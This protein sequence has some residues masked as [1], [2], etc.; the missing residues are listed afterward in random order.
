MKMIG[1]F[2]LLNQTECLLFRYFCLVNK[3]V[4]YFNSNRSS[5]LLAL[6]EKERF[7][8]THE[9]PSLENLQAFLDKHKGQY[10]MGYLSYDLKETIFNSK[11]LNEDGLNFPLAFFWVPTYV[12][13]LKPEQVDFLQGEKNEEILRFVNHFLEEETDQNFHKHAFDFHPKLSKERYIEQVN[14]L[15]DHIAKGDIYEVNFCQEFYA[16][17][18]ELPYALDAYLKL[19]KFTLAPHSC[20]LDIDQQVVCCASPE[21]FIRK[22]GNRLESQ[23]IKGT[24][25]RGNTSE[26][27]I[28]LKEELLADKK[29]RAENIMIVDLV[30]NDLSRIALPGSVRVDELCEVYTFETVHQMISTISCE[31]STHTSFTDIIRATFPMGSMT[32]APKKRAIEL[33][34]AHENFKRGL[35][36]GTIGVIKPNGDF[37]FNVVI[38][39]LLYNRDSKYLSCAVGSAITSLS[40]PEKE[41]EECLVKVQRIMDGIN[42]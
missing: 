41:Y 24:A 32:G 10:L 2:F 28:R 12:V 19:N 31:V 11:S 36:S 26:E 34:E 18:A 23:P 37:D 4:A 7:V 13:D 35:Y 21:R 14:Q 22:T 6:G 5:G 39:S 40:V 15:K 33:I 1:V 27:D 16:E 20:F 17:K 38:R 9:N 25:R 8:M 3:T 42:A 29:E 30:R